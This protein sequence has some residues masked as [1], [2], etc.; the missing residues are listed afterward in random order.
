MASV[1]YSGSFNG[2][3]SGSSTTLYGTAI[4][5]S[6]TVTSVS[7]SLRVKSSRYSSSYEWVFDSFSISGSGLSSPY[8]E[9]D[10]MYSSEYTFTGNLGKCAASV[11]SGSY[12]SVTAQ[13]HNTGPS[14]YTTYLWDASVTVNYNEAPTT[15]P[16]YPVLTARQNGSKYEL[17]WTTGSV[18]NSSGQLVACT[19]FTVWTGG[20]HSLNEKYNT[21]NT[22]LTIDV[23]PADV[24][25]TVRFYVEAYTLRDDIPGLEVLESNE[26]SITTAPLSNYVSYGVNGSWKDCVAHY[27][28]GDQWVECTPYYGSGGKWVECT[29]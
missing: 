14:N 8:I 6:V 10:T 20:W 7:F 17:S 19:N 2:A 15:S 4:P 24:G 26:V 21:T 13:A 18:V 5:S 11:F 22:Y 28:A 12:I 27:G 9:S 3:T 1:T 16:V 23:P 29:K 25:Q